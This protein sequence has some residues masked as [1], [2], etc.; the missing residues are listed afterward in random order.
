[1]KLQH[2]FHPIRIQRW[3]LV[4]STLS[5]AL[6]CLP[7]PA[8]G[9]YAAAVLADEPVAYWRLGS[10]GPSEPD[11]S[12][13]GHVAE[14]DIDLFSFG[15]DSLIPPDTDTAL[16]IMGDRLI[17]DPFEK[18][19][20]GFAVEFLVK[21]EIRP[22]AFTNLVGDGED[23]G[24]FNLM[25][26]LTPEGKVRP[27]VQTT[28]GV[29]AVDSVQDIA[30]GRLHHIVSTW[31][32]E[33]GIH[34]LYI[35]GLV[36]E[37][38]PVAGSL[39]LLGDP[40]NTGNSIFLGRDGREGGHT[41]VLDEVAIYDK[42]LASDRVEAHAAMIDFPPPPSDVELPDPGDLED[43]PDGLAH[44]NDFNEAAGKKDGFTLDFAYDRIGTAD[45]AFEG[46]SARTT[47]LIGTGAATFDNTPGS[48]VNVGNEGFEAT[49]G[50]AIEALIV[51][52]WSGS[53]GDYDEI[54]RKEDGGNR[55]LF[56]FQNDAF[57]ENANPP[58]TANIPVLSFGLN[59]GGYGE[60]DLPLDGTV[61]GV[62]LESLTDGM[63]HHVV[64]NYDSASGEK[65]IW[66]DG[67]KAWSVM[68][69]AGTMVV[70][71]GAAPAYIGNTNGGAEAFTGTID[72]FA[73]WTRALSASEIADHAAAVA[74]KRNYFQ[75]GE[76]A[77]T[78][79]DEI[80]LDSPVAY[81]RL[82]DAGPDD[83]VD[84]SGN[85][86]DG[87]AEDG[88][89]EFGQSSLIP[90]D[91]DTSIALNGDRIYVDGFDKADTGFS[92]EFWTQ[93][94]A[95][96]G[97]F[98][99]LVGDG[100]GGLNFM[101]MVYLTPGGN[102]RPHVQTA[103]GFGSLDSVASIAD[104]LLHHIVSTWDQASGEMVLYI[105]GEVADVIVSAGIFPTT[106]EAIN[107]ENPIFIGRDNRES[108]ADFLIDEVAIYDYA[109]APDRI[110]AHS[111]RV[112]RDVVVV[113]PPHPDPGNIADAPDGLL[114]YIDLD[115]A[116][117]E[118]EGFKTNFA[119]DRVGSIEGSFQG[120]TARVPGLVGVGAASFDNS[121]GVGIN[122]GAVGF[123]T[124]TGISVEMLFQSDWSG[125][126]Y[127]EFFRKEDG[128]DRIL[129]SYQADGFNGS[130]N[131]PIDDGIPVLSFGLNVDG[132]YGELD[133]PL[134][135]TNDAELS[136]EDL[137]DGTTHHI[138]ATFDSIT[139][140]KAIW[141]DGVKAWS[142][143]LGEGAV[144]TSGG[145]APAFIGSTNGNEPFTG[146]ID[147]FA[148]WER[149]LTEEEI[150]THA[151]NGLSGVSIIAPGK[152]TTGFAITEFVF[153]SESKVITAKWNSKPGATYNF[154][155]ST[156]L[157][158]WSEVQDSIE[159]E[160]TETNIDIDVTAFLQDATE[161]YFRFTIP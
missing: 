81:W 15:A 130:A 101:L 25:V 47:G 40:V 109:L 119:Y 1:M 65:S 103:D 149:P 37:V 71:G 13:N 89:L 50:I 152:P 121:P 145:G 80:S 112:D 48:G 66:V 20:S 158:N 87:F 11:A 41:F 97:G 93:I 77:E 46:T 134:D 14:P 102:V 84:I 146:I 124:S 75:G 136:V 88:V 17:T 56:S 78:Y 57:N 141:I 6:V 139:G 64:A 105:D 70:S 148:F 120:A 10:E 52:S 107:D 67:V 100:D 116:A 144:I 150:I 137:A 108:G 153:D 110:K 160:G 138:A 111:D 55:I 151:A 143:N 63:P 94:E 8:W 129:L 24:N 7:H 92:V 96:A 159:S 35:D 12:G 132:E 59:A 49:S 91:T 115:E 126:D 42:V 60:L 45:G 154:E 44:Y 68:L 135:G 104:G 69:P 76:L 51:S 5:L 38:T 98:V 18:I 140:E 30:D 147:E 83:A 54:F 61:E 29:F 155:F 23:G 31:D 21:V 34:L 3:F 99:N 106:G 72:E 125:G 36:A 118:V 39:P 2:T 62:T 133:M 128:G 161:A 90:P 27:H 28:S 9:Q 16:E 26:Y 4:A 79:A 131:P 127:D 95:P 43:L 114:H 156:D 82:G 85:G 122:L 53:D 22:G 117:G 86:H 73:F 113:D 142:V 58:V 33:T 123:E 19:D 157:Q 74:L 32:K